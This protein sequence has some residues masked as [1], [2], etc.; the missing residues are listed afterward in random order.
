[1][2]KWQWFLLILYLAAAA[3]H[4]GWRGV[5]LWADG[6]VWYLLLPLLAWES[7]RLLNSWRLEPTGVSVRFRLVMTVINIVVIGGF[8]LLLTSWFA[9]LG[10]KWSS[11][12]VARAVACASVAAGCLTMAAYGTSKRTTTLSIPPPND[13]EKPADPGR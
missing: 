9:S 4:G 2:N 11:V 6:S 5:D 8:A 13:E 12:P 10:A 3:G 1:M 7:V